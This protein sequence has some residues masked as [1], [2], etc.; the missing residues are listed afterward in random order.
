MD[1][2]GEAE[3]LLASIEE[4]LRRHELDA[5]GKRTARAAEALLRTSTSPRALA[6][7]GWLLRWLGEL[8]EARATFE[9]ALS[10]APGTAEWL[11]A[12]RGQA[13]LASMRG[14][15]AEAGDVLRRGL[16]SRPD[17]AD[18]RARLGTSLYYQGRIEAAAAELERVPDLK[19]A[20]ALLAMIRRERK[21]PE[22]PS[23]PSAELL[24]RALERAL[25]VI[26]ASDKTPA[27]K[28][29]A[30]AKLREARRRRGAP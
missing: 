24:D 3:R 22:P 16:E 18:L 19:E 2:C 23:P 11:D 9:K 20:A 25:E 21:S 13:E 7:L 15:E 4:P 8:E 1:P 6:R 10:T 14:R 29:D 30:E 5:K 12:V 17:D 27:E 26:R 28:A